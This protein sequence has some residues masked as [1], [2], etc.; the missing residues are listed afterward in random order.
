MNIKSKE[1][2]KKT[3]MNASKSDKI[4]V[5]PKIDYTTLITSFCSFCA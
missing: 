1:P 4:D 5:N 2:E 3:T